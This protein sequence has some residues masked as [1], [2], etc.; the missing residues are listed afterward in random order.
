[1]E[2][3]PKRRSLFDADWGR[4]RRRLEGPTPIHHSTPDTGPHYTG[5]PEEGR[6]EINRETDNMMRKKV[7]RFFTNDPN[8]PSDEFRRLAAE[9]SMWASRQK[10]HQ[11]TGMIQD[12]Y[13]KLSMRGDAKFRID[14]SG[15][16]VEN[17]HIDTN[18][19]AGGEKEITTPSQTEILDYVLL[20]EMIG[21]TGAWYIP[22]M[23]AVFIP[24]GK[25]YEAENIETKANLKFLMM[26]SCS[27]DSQ[28]PVGLINQ[29]TYREKWCK[30]EFPNFSIEQI[31]RVDQGY[32]AYQGEENL[33]EVTMIA[34]YS[35]IWTYEGIDFPTH[36]ESVDPGPPPEDMC[37]YTWFIPVE[38]GGPG[39]GDYYEEWR[40]F[41]HIEDPVDKEMFWWPTEFNQFIKRHQQWNVEGCLMRTV[42]DA[43]ND[44]A[45]WD[46]VEDVGVLAAAGDYAFPN[47]YTAYKTTYDASA[48]LWGIVYGTYTHAGYDYPAETAFPYTSIP[49]GLL[50]DNE[51]M[52]DYVRF[53][54]TSGVYVKGGGNEMYI[55]GV[56]RRD[57]GAS[58]NR[59]VGYG[60]YKRDPIDLDAGFLHPEELNDRQITLL[61]GNADLDV[62][63]RPDPDFTTLTTAEHSVHTT[64]P[65]KFMIRC[66]SSEYFLKDQEV[67]G[68]YSAYGNGQHWYEYLT[69]ADCFDYGIFTKLGT[70][71]DQ[72]DK[73][74]GEKVDPIY[75]YCMGFGDDKIS[76][77]SKITII[78]GMIIDG[79]HYRTE[80][81]SFDSNGQ[82]V[83]I[84]G[85]EEAKD[86]DDND[87]FCYTKVRV[88]V[89]KMKIDLPVITDQYE[90]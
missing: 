9:G 1:M 74:D 58:I 69:N 79:L 20:V 72:D 65:G 17:I 81:F 53:W 32:V 66:G 84:P 28:D 39:G 23:F 57:S 46:T 16:D 30:T 54:M 42:D 6:R 63:W 59:T 47:T 34:A 51:T 38:Y 52:S 83:L 80:E 22:K 68:T 40:L 82:F 67:T 90:E 2:Q 60:V 71:F 10:D 13:K 41:W 87:I 7:Q 26:A 31:K 36:W 62:D 77:D 27:G 21:E 56:E 29:I 8:L 18:W 75:A 48:R 50:Y 78:Y 86:E 24:S 55:Q 64:S 61:E 19:P 14:A 15:H 37:G 3:L 45:W 76:G 89:R 33:E 49:E 85:T 25:G 44:F 73:V 43:A 5:S 11:E 12:Y 4:K 70:G 35:N 88:G